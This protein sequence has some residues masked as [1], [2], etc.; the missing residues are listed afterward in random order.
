MGSA[1][2]RERIMAASRYN[3]SPEAERE[4]RLMECGWQRTRKQAGDIIIDA[5]GKQEVTHNGWL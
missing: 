2:T 5:H 4:T 1:G 3:P